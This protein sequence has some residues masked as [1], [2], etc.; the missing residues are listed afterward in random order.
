MHYAQNELRIFIHFHFL[1]DF[2]KKKC[3]LEI[4]KAPLKAEN[5]DEVRETV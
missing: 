3:I 1:L 5:P 2:F 4:N